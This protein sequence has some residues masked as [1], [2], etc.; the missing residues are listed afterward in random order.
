MGEIVAIRIGI[1]NG[2]DGAIVAIDQAMNVISTWEMP[3]NDVGV[4]RRKLDKETGRMKTS[5]G[6]KRVLDMVLGHQILKLLNSMCSDIY[7]ILESCQTFPGEGISTAFNA[8]RRRN[9][10]RRSLESTGRAA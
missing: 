10:A 3:S 6:T 2:A 5:A 8:G 4:S 1:D 7:V 9:S